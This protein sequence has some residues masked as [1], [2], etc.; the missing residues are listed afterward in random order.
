[1]RKYLMMHPDA[2]GGGGV[3]APVSEAPANTPI[4]QAMADAR[5]RMEA[6]QPLVPAAPAEAPAADPPRNA[7]GTFAAPAEAP[8]EETTVAEGSD[9]QPSTEPNPLV[10]E[11]PGRREGDA[12]DIIEASSPEQAE[13]IR[14]LVNGYQRGEVLRQQQAM[15]QADRAA[16]AEISARLE[17]DPEGFLFESIP[18][19]RAA[20]VALQVLLQPDV[21]AQVNDVLADLL[22]S[23]DK[24]ELVR[25]SLENTRFK[26][27]EAVGRQMEEQRE[28]TRNAVVVKQSIA[29]MIPETLPENDQVALY[30]ACQQDVIEYAERLGLNVLDP[31]DVPLI[32]ANRLRSA[33]VDPVAAAAALQN[34]SR[35]KSTPNGTARGQAPRAPA[36]P[37]ASAQPSGKDFV[38]AAAAARAAATTAPAG[39]GAPSSA[40]NAKPPAGQTLEERIKWSRDNLKFTTG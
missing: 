4:Q 28:A 18:Q 7:D 15:V 39:A 17:L 33:G 40:A 11:L 31:R 1:M 32:V 21:W 19:E 23:D 26:N 22:D 37:A 9:N 30:N 29:M 36:R 25:V 34:V 35:G 20:S 2:E 24:R 10:V 3:A 6:G 8:A 38:A 27:K 16:I 12:P 13:R 5:A 14:Q